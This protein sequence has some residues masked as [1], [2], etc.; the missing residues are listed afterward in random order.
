M[1]PE[2]RSSNPVIV[3]FLNTIFF[4]CQLCLKDEISEKE[5]KFTKEVWALKRF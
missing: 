5:A 4:P 1:T 2:V 3:E